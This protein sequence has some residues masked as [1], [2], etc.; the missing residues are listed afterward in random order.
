MLQLLRTGIFDDVVH[1]AKLR[2]GRLGEDEGIQVGEP[3]AS[4]E[5]VQRVREWEP[6]TDQVVEIVEVQSPRRQVGKRS[7]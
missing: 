4:I 1:E 7:A 5:A 2:D 3:H 6:R